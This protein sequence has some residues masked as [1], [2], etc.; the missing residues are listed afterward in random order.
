MLNALTAAALKSSGA[1]EPSGLAAV[2]ER[3]SIRPSAWGWTAV[4]RSLS[5]IVVHATIYDMSADT[6]TTAEAAERL[7]VSARQVQRLVD[8]GS[9]RGAGRV[10][11]SLLLDAD[12]VLALVQQGTGRGRRWHADTAWAALWL[13][14][15]R[16][17]VWQDN[18]SRR[19]HLRNRL[20]HMSVEDYIRSARTRADVRAYRASASLLDDVAKE[21]T[22]TGL[23][24]LK[25]IDT[26]TAL[27]LAP[28]R[29]TDS[30]DGYV[31]RVDLD[32]L[33]ERFFLVADN[34]GNLTL[35][36]VDEGVVWLEQGGLAAL[37]VVAL[38]LAESLDPR[39][40]SAGA[41]YLEQLAARL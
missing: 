3:V 1:T 38:D 5:Y 30:L 10:G 11:R 15:G 2:R 26:A 12:S 23:S 35:R 36:V 29:S 13:L 24:A 6:M 40:R 33:V 39:L 4:R 16:S 7:Q 28:A 25:D 27:G 37:E 31:Y 18:V 21:V 20:E 41:R 34:A 14:A 9:I 32:D 8:N 19:W 17:D 22:G